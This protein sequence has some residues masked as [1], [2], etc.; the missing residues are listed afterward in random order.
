MAVAPAPAAGQSKRRHIAIHRAGSTRSLCSVP[1]RVTL[2]QASFHLAARQKQWLPQTATLEQAA[3][4][5]ASY[6]YRTPSASHP[7]R[8]QKIVVETR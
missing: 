7:D 4:A 1:R 8:R 3:L 2:V 6:G 5:P